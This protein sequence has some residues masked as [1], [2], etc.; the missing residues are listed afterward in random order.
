MIKLLI[1]LLIVFVIPFIIGCIV[2]N[3]SQGRDDGFNAFAAFAG[4][5]FFAWLIGGMIY[6]AHVKTENYVYGTYNLSSLSLNSYI[7]STTSKT[8]VSNSTEERYNYYIKSNDAYN[9]YWI[10]SNYATL[11]LKE[12]ALDLEVIKVKYEPTFF[13]KYVFPNIFINDDDVWNTFYVD[14]KYAE[15]NLGIKV[16]K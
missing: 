4:I 16:G 7:K 10:N 6:G 11:K 9:S 1:F 13:T 12:G 8:S 15:E 14:P 3:L 5:F 2:D